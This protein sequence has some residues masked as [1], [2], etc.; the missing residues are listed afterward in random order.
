[1]TNEMKQ[2]AGNVGKQVYEASAKAR[3]IR[4]AGGCN[5]L[6]GLILEGTSAAKQ[7]PLACATGIAAKSSG[8]VGG[9]MSGG[10]SALSN[11]LDLVNGEKDAGEALGCIAR[12]TAG[13]ALSGA[14]AAAAA[15]VTGTAVASAVAGTAIAGTAIGTA[16]V[17]AAPAAVAICVG[18]VISTIWDAIWD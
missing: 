4:N 9:A 12:D 3:A 14:G 2:N 11:T 18:C 5:N 6:N 10:L 16:C 15:T 1:M 8:I 7:V 17:V 13:G